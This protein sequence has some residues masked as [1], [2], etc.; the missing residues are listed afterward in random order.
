MLQAPLTRLAPLRS[1]SGA[2]IKRLDVGLFDVLLVW[3]R[4]QD[5]VDSLGMNSI[6]IRCVRLM[7]AIA[8][9]EKWVRRKE[10]G[11]LD[12]RGRNS[13]QPSPLVPHYRLRPVI[14]VEP[15]HEDDRTNERGD[16]AE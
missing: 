1:M 3:S 13:Q 9:H 5:D 14:N 11:L 4:R 16:P 8:A 2:V 15:K 7:G 10:M 6:K 12:K